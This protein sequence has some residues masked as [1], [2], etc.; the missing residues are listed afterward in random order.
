MLDDIESRLKS[1]LNKISSII[2][3]NKRKYKKAGILCTSEV[4]YKKPYFKYDKYSEKRLLEKYIDVPVK[5]LKVS[6]NEKFHN[7]VKK[8]DEFN[9]CL[10]LS[11]TLFFTYHNN[12][13]FNDVPE[14][15]LY[16]FSEEVAIKEYN[17]REIQ[18]LINL[19]IS[20]LTKRQANTHVRIFAYGIKPDKKYALGDFLWY[21]NLIIR[22][23]KDD[24][25][26]LKPGLSPFE[27]EADIWLRERRLPYN[28]T[29]IIEFDLNNEGVRETSTDICWEIERLLDIFRL[30]KLG[31]VMALKWDSSAIEISPAL[32]M[33]PVYLDKCYVCDI[34]Y[35]I[36]V[37]DIPLIKQELSRLVPIMPL[38]LQYNPRGDI[39]Y[40][41]IALKWYKDALLYDIQNVINKERMALLISTSYLSLESIFGSDTE[42]LKYNLSS[43][44]E[45]FGYNYFN[46]KRDLDHAEVIRNTVFHGSKVAIPS[47]SLEYINF[48]FCS[49]DFFYQT[50]LEYNRLSI[51]FF[52]LMTEEMAKEK[53]IAD[54]TGLHEYKPL[55][56]EMI[57]KSKSQDKKRLELERFVKDLI[58][59]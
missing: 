10:R 33:S 35:D 18:N 15:L 53:G 20:D 47:K 45:N 42:K 59:K 40:I 21:R 13:A 48:N 34:G 51:L 54:R 41:D 56:I 22:E 14:R 27:S 39:T 19:F 46:V 43:L 12:I 24:D 1:S 3:T 26:I 9:E 44:M 25:Y 55:I 49:I 4:V 52:I 5:T 57:N 36:T 6:N 58:Y 8:L 37:I 23:P 16:A 28:L 38:D 11:T 50:I 7:H 2:I 32:F 31:R 29:A 30:I 17:N